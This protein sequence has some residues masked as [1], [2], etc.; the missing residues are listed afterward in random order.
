MFCRSLTAFGGTDCKEVREE[1]SSVLGPFSKAKIGRD[2][3]E[4]VDLTKND[5]GTHVVGGQNRAED[6]VV[7]TIEEVVHNAVIP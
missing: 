5:Y 2:K 7:L 6:G 1:V 4:L 3:Q